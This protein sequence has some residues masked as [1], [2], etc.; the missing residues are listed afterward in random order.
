MNKSPE[1]ILLILNYNGKKFLKNCLKSALAASEF[2]GRQVVRLIDNSSSDG[3]VEFV[4]EMFPDI[5]IEVHPNR[6]LFSYNEAVRNAVTP[7]VFLLN[8]DVELKEDC[9]PPL[10]KHFQDPC[11]FAVQSKHI[12]KN[13]EEVSG[14]GKR[15]FSTVNKRG[16]LTVY[17]RSELK[18]AAPTACASG[19]GSL[20][21]RKKFIELGGFDPLFYPAYCEDLDL[22]YRAWKRGWYS[23]YEPR[24]IVYHEH[25]GTM[26]SY[27]LSD[28]IR[29][30]NERNR[31]LFTWKNIQ[32]RGFLPKHGLF[33]FPRLLKR[34]SRGSI[35]SDVLLPALKRLPEV[36]RT[37]RKRRHLVLTDSQV[38][39]LVNYDEIE[40]FR[41]HY[42]N[43]VSSSTASPAL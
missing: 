33:L 25:H 43:L 12:T 1:I 42:E 32:I 26:R 35:I 2:A 30:L 11:L 24:S 17:S 41:F 3:S 16:F 20:I 38:W 27:Y 7:Y 13:G 40:L 23:L 37:R 34:E 28:R 15:Y 39:E 8:N 6:F 29:M 31:L 10:L 4:Q 36:I 18:T 14:G 5:E 21:D 22:T 19:G 9:I